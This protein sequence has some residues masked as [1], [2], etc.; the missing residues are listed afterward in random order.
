MKYFIHAGLLLSIHCVSINQQ[1]HELLI[2][3]L[4]NAPS[5]EDTAQVETQDTASTD[6]AQTDAG[7]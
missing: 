5:T 2:E 3:Q 6:T 1:E 4:E 7:S